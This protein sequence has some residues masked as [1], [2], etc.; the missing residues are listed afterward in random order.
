MRLAVSCIALAAAFAGM[1]AVEGGELHSYPNGV[2][3]RRNSY[4]VEFHDDAHDAHLDTVRNHPSVKVKHHHGHLFKGMTV[5]VDGAGIPQQLS[6]HQGVKRVWPNRIHTLSSS[7]YSG[8]GPSQTLHEKTGLLKVAKEFGLDGKG[9]KIGII[10]TGVD[11]GHPD[12]GGCWKEEGCPWQYG[13]DFIGDEYDEHSDDPV[14]K[15]NPTPMDCNGHGTHV[16][17]IL[18]ARGTEVRGI[19]PNATFGMYRA[20]SC[21]NGKDPSGSDDSIIVQAMEAAVKD[22]H[23]IISMSLGAD[24]AWGESLLGVQ[25]EKMVSKGI[26]AVAASGN[27]GNYGMLTAGAP[28]TADGIISVG[29]VNNWSVRSIPM[30]ISTPSTTFN[31]FKTNS[32]SPEQEFVFENKTPI[33]APKDSLG[34]TNGCNPFT[35][36]LTNKVALV[37]RGNCSFIEKAV[38]AQDAG[39]KGIVVYNNVGG[40]LEAPL[41]DETVK[42]PITIIS[43]DD[44]ENIA[45]VASQGP[46]FVSAS[47]DVYATFTNDKGGLMAEFSAFGPTPELDMGVS[48]SAPGAFIWST[49]PRKMGNYITM[50]GTSMATPYVSGAAALLKQAR[51]DMSV[52]EIRSVLTNTAKPVEDPASKLKASPY[53]SGGGLLDIYNAVKSRVQIDPPVLAINDTQYA[54][55]TGVVHRISKDDIRWAIRT[56]KIKNTDKTKGLRISMDHAPASSVTMFNTTGMIIDSILNVDNDAAVLVDTEASAKN[57]MPRVFSLDS[58]QYIAPGMTALVTVTIASPL[59]LDDNRW[60][61]GGY[62][63]FTMQWSGESTKSNYVVPYAG[64]KGEFNKVPILA[65]KSSGFP[66]IVNSDGDFIKDVSKLKVSAKNPVAVAFFMNMPS[67]LVTSELIDSSGKP[68]G[69]LT[70]GYNP[71]IS[72]T[73]GSNY[74]TTPLYGSVFTDKEL[75]NSVNVTAGQY[76]IR[77]SA[78]KLFGNIERPSDFEVW[79]SETFTVE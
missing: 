70:Y 71:F 65:P 26:V 52:S 75:K 6:K 62:L 42:I 67:K 69:Y 12:L 9:V 76:H 78:L 41:V 77:L 40:S 44:G 58:N 72:R 1:S 17:G 13:Q 4:I 55:F 46:T 22:G 64:F 45:D 27:A 16:S 68:V 39:A 20:F 63:N 23:D 50:S 19:A 73:I 36:D 7:K 11:Y 66:A 60:F 21:G 38:F 14:I 56:L 32:G 59:G 48:V 24:G 8:K 5:T 15:P 54:P 43:K 18:A 28:A 34:N 10:D 49:Y 53:Q 30:T 37:M 74:F 3:V 57:T 29:A 35:V 2:P 33:V 31:V 25:A 79:N 47:K 51:P 61:Y